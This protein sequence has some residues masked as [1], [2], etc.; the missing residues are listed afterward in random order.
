MNLVAQTAFSPVLYIFCESAFTRWLTF[1][2]MEGLLLSWPI[3][4]NTNDTKMNPGQE[5]CIAVCCCSLSCP[6][7]ERKH[8]CRQWWSLLFPTVLTILILFAFHAALSVSNRE[9]YTFTITLST[10][11]WLSCAAQ[12]CDCGSVL[13]I[14]EPVL[15]SNW[16]THSCWH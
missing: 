7:L 16:L 11:L 14:N 1:K 2:I 4:D 12:M 15:C 8:H 10:F 5:Q 13:Y 6:L 9:R 3:H